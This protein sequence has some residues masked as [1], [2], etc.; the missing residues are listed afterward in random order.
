MGT[1]MAM[2]QEI[3]VGTNGKEQPSGLETPQDSFLGQQGYIAVSA[4]DSSKPAW[5]L[6]PCFVPSLRP[7]FCVLNTSTTVLT[8][9]SC[10][11]AAG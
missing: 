5:R 1:L 8:H 4:K 11:L 2:S 9:R 3:G 7:W 10:I 6:C